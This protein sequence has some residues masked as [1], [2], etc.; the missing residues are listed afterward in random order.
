MLARS[1][2]LGVARCGALLVAVALSGALP[3]LEGLAGDRAHACACH[4]PPGEVCSCAGCRRAAEK[5]RRDHLASLPP[6]HRA[7][8]LAVAT[9]AAPPGVAVVT[10]CCHAPAPDPLVLEIFAPYLPP[11]AEVIAPAGRATRAPCTALLAP[12]DVV[13]APPTPPPRLA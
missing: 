3:H 6:C 9:R 8:A 4:H 13:R 5:Q 11:G 7:A 12:R 2:E 10:G 1:L